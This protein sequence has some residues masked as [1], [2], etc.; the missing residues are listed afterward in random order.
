MQKIV[1]LCLVFVVF[2][3][4]CC[5]RQTQQKYDANTPQELIDLYEKINKDAKNP[6]LFN[7]LAL[8]FIK[9]QQLDS[10]LNAISKAIN[11]D[12]TNEN[13]FLTLSDVYFAQTNVDLSE[14]ALEKALS[15]NPKNEEASLKLA[16]LHFLLKRYDLSQKFVE[17]TLK[18]N[19]YN[20]K[21]YFL[22]GW[23]FREKGDTTMAISNYLKATEQNSDYYD[24]Y[25]ELGILYQSRLNA[26]A[27]D[28]YN[29][30]LN[31]KP[32]DF[33]ALYNKAMFYQETEDYDKA[34]EIYKM[35]LQNDG[36]NKL[37]LHNMGW[38]YLAQ[39][40]YEEGFVF[41]SKAIEEDES[42]IEAIYNRGLCSEMLN[43]TDKARQD[44]MYC[45]KLNDHYQLAIDGLNRLN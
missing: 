10:A 39:R 23:I 1:N 27:V 25:M 13:Y 33:Q 3:C 21:A 37:A 6:E 42:Y 22:L 26:L 36:H 4:I 30:A 5:H 41:F 9:N 15:I 18:L 16:E 24:A 44:F 28:Y 40:K 8:Y 11:L 31:C 12:S 43:E 20:P 38:I 32:N 29:N 7:N 34:L 17:Q 45:L 14:D 19:D 35:I 2:C